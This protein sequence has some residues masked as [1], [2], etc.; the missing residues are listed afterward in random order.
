MFTFLSILGQAKSTKKKARVEPQVDDRKE[1]AGDVE[2]GLSLPSDIWILSKAFFSSRSRFATSPDL[3]RFPLLQ[4]LNRHILSLSCNLLESTR[5]FATYSL[6]NV[7]RGRFGRNTSIDSISLNSNTAKRE[8]SLSSA[9]ST[10]TSA[11]IALDLQPTKR[12]G[13]FL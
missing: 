6:R 8:T 2:H 3:S 5:P 11:L 10:R 12:I 9:S 7:L 4:S 1:V 13:I